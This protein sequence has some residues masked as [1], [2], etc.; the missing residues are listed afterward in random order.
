MCKQQ[1]CNRLRRQL[2]RHTTILRITLC[3]A[4]T[5]LSLNLSY[6]FPKMSSMP[7][8]ITAYGSHHFLKTYTPEPNLCP[9]PS[10]NW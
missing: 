5:M 6:A 10:Q 3:Y 2:K 7:R 4:E 8:Q 1:P 9:L